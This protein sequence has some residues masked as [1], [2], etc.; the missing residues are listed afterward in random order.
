MPTQ[1]RG[2]GG[3]TLS[4][5]VTEP[6]DSASYAPGRLLCVEEHLASGRPVVIAF[7]DQGAPVRCWDVSDLPKEWHACTQWHPS[8]VACLGA[9]PES[10]SVSSSPRPG[11]ARQMAQWLARTYCYTRPIL[12]ATS[13]LLSSRKVFSGAVAS[14]IRQLPSGS[15]VLEVG[16]NQAVSAASQGSVRYLVVDPAA[17]SGQP[18]GVNGQHEP[19][20][21]QRVAGIAEDLPVHDSSV[22]CLVCLFVLEH[23]IEPRLALTEFRRVLR[24]GGTLLLGMPVDDL[25]EG[26][27]PFQHRWRFT[28]A[29]STT[30]P[31]TIPLRTLNV[32]SMGFRNA[33]RRGWEAWLGSG[34]AKLFRFRR[35]V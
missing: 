18:F 2:L 28:S 29:D 34:D 19:A 27:P 24:P 32:R 23:L 11:E 1:R 8:G 21:E 31:R 20:P 10:G 35:Q 13:T 16:G 7:D 25:S 6:T 33:M 30:S 3:T 17:E 5:M 4:A 14:V 12:G 15:T 22:D 26:C 9:R